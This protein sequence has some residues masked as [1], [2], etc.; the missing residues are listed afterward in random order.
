MGQNSPYSARDLKRAVNI[1]AVLGWLVVSAP[2]LFG[3]GLGA[4][5]F[6]A[7]I[8][9]PIAF[10]VCWMTGAPI[11][12]RA[13]RKPV[14]WMRAAIYGAGISFAIAALSIVIAR[15][16]GFSQSLNENSSSQ[17]GGGDY[18]QSIDGI[19]TPYGWYLTGQS[20]LL[21]M[22]VGIVIALIMRKV[23]GGGTVTSAP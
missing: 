10:G 18:I 1:S 23:I 14:T 4:F 5:P 15:L 19:L 8:G 6:V 7:V 3:L 2:F 22:C 13:M 17:V 9:L 16:I 21:F 11:L 12:S 20:T